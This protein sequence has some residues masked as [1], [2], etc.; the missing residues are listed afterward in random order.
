MA[1]QH[2][3]ACEDLLDFRRQSNYLGLESGS[4]RCSTEMDRSSQKSLWGGHETASAKAVIHSQLE[5]LVRATASRLSH[6]VL[7]ASPS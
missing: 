4:N 6:A 2:I 3:G 5:A 1:H 7:V